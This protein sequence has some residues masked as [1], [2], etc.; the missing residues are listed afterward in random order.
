M[1]LIDA[2]A[3]H[4]TIL[5]DEKLDGK[6]V[7]WAVNRIISHILNAPTIE[8]NDCVLKEFGKCSYKETGCSDCKIKSNLRYMCHGSAW[9]ELQALREFKEK[10]EKKGKWIFSGVEHTD[11]NPIDS[12][13]Y[14]CSVCKRSISTT[15]TRPTELFPFCHCGADMRGDV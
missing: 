7:N 13:I 3:L 2:N 5:R 15:L 1:R 8:P 11:D 6:D 4:D 10:H 9:Q 12:D 14:Y